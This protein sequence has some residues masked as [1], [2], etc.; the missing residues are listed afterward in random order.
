MLL[1]ISSISPFTSSPSSSSLLSSCCSCCPTPSLS[2]MSWINTLRTSAE[3]FGTLAENNS[4]NDSDQAQSSPVDL[5]IQGEPEKSPGNE[6]QEETSLIK[7]LVKQDPESPNQNQMMAGHPQRAT[8]RSTKR[9]LRTSRTLFNNKAIS[10]LMK[11]SRSQTQYNAH[12]ETPVH[13][14]CTCGAAKSWRKRRSQGEKVMNCFNI[15]TTSAFVF[16]TENNWNQQSLSIVSQSACPSQECQ[17]VTDNISFVTK[18]LKVTTESRLSLKK[19][20]PR[21][22]DH[23]SFLWIKVCG[24]PFRLLRNTITV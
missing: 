3:D 6:D 15:L 13:T 20:H 19:L 22:E 17:D 11:S 24:S 8:K 21:K 12:G 9:C 18:I 7:L 14:Y 1:L 10:K 16:G 2:L 23:Q 4:S 5:L